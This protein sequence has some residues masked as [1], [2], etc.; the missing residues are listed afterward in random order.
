MVPLYLPGDNDT[1][2]SVAWLTGPI[3]ELF[4]ATPYIRSNILVLHGLRYMH[5]IPHINPEDQ[6]IC[7]GLQRK[8]VFE[9][10]SIV[11]DWTTEFTI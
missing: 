6:S 9:G 1:D 3:Y 4:F 10:V 11:I 8:V 2:L 7:R 5:T